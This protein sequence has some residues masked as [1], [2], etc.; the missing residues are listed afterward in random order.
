VFGNIVEDQV[1]YVKSIS[2]VTNRITLSLTVNGETFAL[3]DDAGYMTAIISVGTGVVWTPPAVYHNGVPLTL[4]TTSVVTRTKSST[5]SITT[6]STGSLVPNQPIVFSDTMFGNVIVPDQTYYVKSIYDYNEF[7]VSETLGGNVLTL[8]D[9]TGGAIFISNDYAIGLADNGIT[10]A[11]LLA[12]DY[13]N[14]VDYLAYT[15]MGETLPVQYGYTLPIIE[16][17][18]GNGIAASFTLTSYTGGN[19]PTN[20]IVEI[21]GVRQNNSAYTINSVTNTIL[22]NSPPANGSTIAVTSYNLTERQYLNTQYNI[23]GS[24]VGTASITISNT[25]K[26]LSGFDQNTPTVATYDENTPSVVLYDQTLYYLTLASGTTSGLIINSAITF[27]NVIG[28]IVAGQTYY[29]TQ[30]LNSTDFVISTQVGGLPFEVTTD[31]GAMTSV[32]NGLT[33]SNIVGIDNAISNPVKISVSGTVDA[34]NSVICNSTAS[35]IVGQ[36]IIFKSAVFTVNASLVGGYQYE[37]ITLGNTTQLQWN[38][39]AGT[40]GVDYAVGDV[41]TALVTGGG[42]GTGTVLLSNLGGIDTLGQVY[43]VRTILDDTH[44]TIEDQYGNIINL[45]DTSGNDLYAFSGGLVAV[46]IIT[47][48]DHNLSENAFIRIDGVKGSIQLNNNTYY[49]KIISNTEF[50]LYTQPYNPAYG[51]TNYPVSNVSAYTS[52][53]YAWLDQL[54]TIATTSTI[55]TTSSNNRI[56]VKDATHIIHGTPVYFTKFGA[57]QDEDILGNILS[58]HEYYVY[59]ATPATVAGNFVVGY[60]YQITILGN[61]NWNTAAGTSGLTYQIGDIFT[62]AASGSGTGIASSLQEFTISETRYPN[63]SEFVLASATDVVNV[64]QF[65]QINVDRLWV[66]VNGL[67]VPSSALKL[68]EYNNLSI[69]STIQTGDVV[70]ITSMMPTAT[71]NEETYLLNVTTSNQPSVYR[72]NTQTRTWLTQALEYSDTMIHLNDVTRVTDNV[73]QNV[74]CPSAVDGLYNIGLTSNKNVICNIVVYNNTTSIE[75]SPDNYSIVIVDTAPILQISAQVATGDSV[76]ITSVE[77]RLLYI[78]GEQI[79]FRECNLADNT[80][81]AL[82]RGT[83]G[84]GTPRYVPINSE[85]F[86]LIP[87]NRMTD[88]LY[89]QSWNSYIYNPVEG[90]PLQISDTFGASFLRTDRT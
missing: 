54:F 84:T 27:E 19:N 85:A 61:T 71:P 83:N 79:G 9:A 48:I 14:T 60:K 3:S 25:T 4:G 74:T 77:G 23:T 45:T 11:I 18:I 6:S 49:A 43:F 24:G 10:A 41:F 73:V 13:N 75:V 63:E 33:V 68:N 29:I 5:N 12:A 8:T 32:V 80:V 17:F 42:V 88:V 22:F 1:Y 76:T 87:N 78:N 70:I 58:Q 39:A 2:G 50:D 59:E 20:A 52:G 64:S 26:L 46:R 69:L 21:N 57:T 90:D 62:A 72:A 38:T 34:N 30:I 35:L 44:F 15:L 37:I 65:Q 81:S 40:T 56:A 82:E 86:G 66:T 36:D 16:I 51:A 89:S 67:R 55:G 31:S 53:G 47:G 28:G 7:T